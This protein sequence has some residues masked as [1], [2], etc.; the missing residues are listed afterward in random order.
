MILLII[1]SMIRLSYCQENSNDYPSVIEIQGDTLIAITEENL[2]SILVDYVDLE[3]YKKK[4]SINNTI[5]EDYKE[6][7]ER[8]KMI[9]FEKDKQ[10]ILKDSIVENQEEIIYNKDKIVDEQ[11]RTIKSLKYFVYCLTA[12]SVVLSIK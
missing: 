11:G 12:L 3:M 4:D 8:Y 5:I 6:N 9:I 2:D 7:N 1:V 10:L